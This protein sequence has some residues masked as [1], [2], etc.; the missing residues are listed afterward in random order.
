MSGKSRSRHKKEHI[1]SGRA[2]AMPPRNPFALAARQKKAGA[3]RKSTSALRQQ[4]AR[5]LAKLVREG[6]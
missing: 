6:D 1:A 3:H 5:K 4:Q 2:L